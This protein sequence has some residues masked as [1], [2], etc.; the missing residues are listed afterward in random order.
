MNGSL[1]IGYSIWLLILLE[2]LVLNFVVKNTLLPGL[3][4]NRACFIWHR[5]IQ[6][7]VTILFQFVSQG[8]D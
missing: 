2:F 1:S 7:F 3:T 5:Y 4:G 8:S 6:A